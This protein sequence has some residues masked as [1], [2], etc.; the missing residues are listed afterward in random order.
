MDYL[1]TLSERRNLLGGMLLIGVLQAVAYYFS[2]LI[3][4]GDGG[5]AI[6][7]TDTLLY[8]QAARR[9]CEGAPFSFTEGNVACTGTTSVLYPFVLAVPYALGCVG[10]AL[11]KAGFALNALFYLVFLFAWGGVID[12]KVRDP[13]ARVLAAVLVALFGQTAYSAFA[14]SDIGFWL[15]TSSL[16]ALGLARNRPWLYGAVLLFGPWVRPEGMVCAIAFFLVAVTCRIFPVKPLAKRDELLALGGILS[17]L[18]V[19]AFNYALTGVA[20]FSSLEHKGHFATRDFANAVV[21]TGAD[22]VTMAKAF[23]LGLPDGIPRDLYFLPLLGALPLWLFVLKRDWLKESDWREWV[24]LVA[25]GGGMLTVAQSGWQNTNMD[26]YIGWLLPTVFVFAAAGVGCLSRRQGGALSAATL[27]VLMAGFAL[28]MA[29]VHVAI[30]HRISEA[31]DILRRYAIEAEAV[32]P[33]GAS[34]AT[35]GGCGVAYEM[36]GRKICHLS[37]IYSMEY[38]AKC[39]PMGVFELLKHEPD[40]RFDYWLH[41]AFALT[42]VP[43]DVTK[44]LGEHVS[45]GPGGYQIL[46]AD[47]SPFDCAARDPAP[48]VAGK[49]L[50]ARVD[51]GYDKDEAAACYEVVSRFGVRP[52]S[53]FL[54]VGNLASEKIVEVGRVVVGLDSMSVPLVPGK[55]VHVVMRTM[56]AREMEVACGELRGPVTYEFSDPLK[57]NVSVDG[58]V[59]GEVS[60]RLPKKGFADVSF[61]IPGEAITSSVSRLSFLGDHIVCGYWFYQ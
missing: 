34:V 44:A 26:R 56:R 10:D 40:K 58:N 53:P 25:V 36:S 1:K 28:V 33:K 12:A 4:A 15:A 18:G 59:V 46:K 48:P 38:R 57:M 24:W 23:F 42:G 7:Q 43:A 37:G 3:V 9:I 5:L 50:V 27:S 19:L 29:V 52:F 51:V 2:A 17:A 16:F 13:L 20:G 35:W 61:D 11:L 60:V 41:N 6:P 54:T 14:Q 31:S 22:L 55:G 21:A 39:P 32:L 47:W 45:T 30:F 49:A 8:C